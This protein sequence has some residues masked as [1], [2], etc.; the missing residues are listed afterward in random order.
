MKIFIIGN[1][2]CGNWGDGVIICGL[3]EEI[4]E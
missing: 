2:I 4:E 1:Y 3:I